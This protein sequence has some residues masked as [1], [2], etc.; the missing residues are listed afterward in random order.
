[1]ESVNLE[2]LGEMM[3]QR[4]YMIR[5]VKRFLSHKYK[6]QGEL[7][8]PLMVHPVE[9]RPQVDLNFPETMAMLLWF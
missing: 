6:T 7:K 9:H 1:M 2:N 5:R 3:R 8:C 4:D